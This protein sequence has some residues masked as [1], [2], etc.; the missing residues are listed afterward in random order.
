MADIETIDSGIQ[1]KRISRIGLGCV[2]FGREIDKTD[3][4]KMMDHALECGITFFDTASAYGNGASEIITG[5][6]LKSRYPVSGSILV[7]TKILPPYDQQ[8]ILNSFS[9]S[10]ERLKLKSIDLVY[11]HRWDNALMNPEAII[12]LG[13]LIKQGKVRAVGASNF[14][15]EQLKTILSMQE[16]NDIPELSFIQNNNNLAVSDITD[17]M[18]GLCLGKK[19]SIVTYSPL[20][21]GFLTGKHIEGVRSGT[22]FE[23]IPGH[24]DIY[25]NEKALNRLSRLMEV[26]NRTGYSQ[27]HLALAWAMHRKG[28][29]SVLIGGRTTSH[30]DQALEAMEFNSREIFD[31]LESESNH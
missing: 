31:E 30:I 14:N 25:F 18:I 23:I 4:F 1:G 9:K 16:E 5:E 3:S 2:T 26:A 15:T 12:V 28:V 19:I 10:L 24:K 21:A 7:A 17:E 13:D 20:A 27:V 11:F 6:W 22:R 8:N 29:A